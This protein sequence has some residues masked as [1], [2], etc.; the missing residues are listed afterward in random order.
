MHR[1]IPGNRHNDSRG[2]LNFFNEFSLEK[3]VRMYE[4]APENTSIVRAWQAH[5]KES[6]WFYCSKGAFTV[7]LVKVDNFN[8]PS[9]DLETFNFELNED[10]PQVLHIPGGYANGF[11]SL[12]N[13]SKLIVFS[14]LDLE[15]SKNDDFRFDTNKWIKKW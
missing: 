9:D 10:T 12:V 8:N 14:D 15:D 11:K 6:K 4:I 2:F 7:N 1:I 3:I 5:K 13:N